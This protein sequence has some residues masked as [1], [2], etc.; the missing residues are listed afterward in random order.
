M[1][2]LTG[3]ILS[4]DSSFT[5]QVAALLR[6]GAIPVSVADG[7]LMPDGGAPPD[8]VIVDGRIDLLSA[9]ASIERTRTSLPSSAI[10]LIAADAT[11]DVILQAMRAGASEFL[12]SPLSDAQFHAALERTAARLD[13]VLGSR[14]KSKTLVFFGVKGGAGTTTIAV[15]CGVELARLSQRPT[16]IVDLKPGLGEATL[17]VGVRSHYT[18][19]DAIDNLNRM[20]TQFL[21]E[22][23]VKHKSGLEVLAGSDQFDRPGPA[24]CAAL[25]EVFRL[26]QRDYEY[27]V[28]DAGSQITPCVTT[29]LY[30]ADSIF[31]VANPDVPSVR[32]AQ[33]LLERIG[34]IGVSRERIRFLLNRAAE[35]YPIPP[36]QI[37]AA[38]GHP[39]DH[40]FPSDYR[41]VS[42]ALNSGV[43]LALTGNTDLAAQF[44]SFTRRVLDLSESPAP[45][46]PG[47]RTTAF[48][49]QRIASI[50]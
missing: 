29:A 43:P 38:I 21:R 28:I 48:S 17:F 34:Q 31:L 44:D 5:S 16:V 4:D 27:V 1:A 15:N 8:I 37:E 46:D 47:R 25:E 35:P 11:P 6:S 10:Y 14:P 23:V 30:V 41:T 12:T 20:D 36:T 50:W 42:S 22:L 39:I 2:R 13:A 45:A 33:R 18:L 24:D 9:I 40:M 7:R 26:L 32:N 3:R 19:L 49:L